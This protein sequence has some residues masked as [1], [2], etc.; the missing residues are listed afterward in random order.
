[1]DV[2]KRKKKQTTQRC[3]SNSSTPR[4]QRWLSARGRPGNNAHTMYL[5]SISTL[6][7]IG[8]YRITVGK[9]GRDDD[10]DK[11]ANSTLPDDAPQWS[12]WIM[13]VKKNSVSFYIVFQSCVLRRVFTVK[14]N[15][16]N[17]SEGRRSSGNR[18]RFHWDFPDGFFSPTNFRVEL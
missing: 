16:W 17:S 5:R 15:T 14:R 10:D 13:E 18:T 3:F 2:K 9:G 11:L 1:M 7:V 12:E 8:R 4:Q 6:T